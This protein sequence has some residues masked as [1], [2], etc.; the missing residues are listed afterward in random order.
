MLWT[1]A[2]TYGL[3]SRSVLFSDGMELNGNPANK[4]AGNSGFNHGTIMRKISPCP[5]RPE[6]LKNKL[7]GSD[8]VVGEN[9]PE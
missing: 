9:S 3:V 1:V 5:Q 4:S 6:I 8:G 2:M 7:H